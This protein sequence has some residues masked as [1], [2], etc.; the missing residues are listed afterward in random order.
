MSAGW[1][2][3]TDLV[4]MGPT[5]EFWGFLFY[6]DNLEYGTNLDLGWGTLRSGNQF[7]SRLNLF[8]WDKAPQVLLR[9]YATCGSAEVSI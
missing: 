5:R 4:G 6:R 7:D 3:R 9:H 2:S 8:F 1:L